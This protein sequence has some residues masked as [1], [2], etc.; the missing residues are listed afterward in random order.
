[1]RNFRFLGDL[2]FVTVCNPHLAQQWVISLPDTMH[3][4]T[5]ML[6]DCWM[7]TARVYWIRCNLQLSSALCRA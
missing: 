2:M 7:S 1:M 4:A 5:M 3:R 6:S